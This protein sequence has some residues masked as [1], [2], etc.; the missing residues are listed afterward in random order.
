MRQLDAL[1]RYFPTGTSEGEQSIL[2]DVFIVPAQLQDVLAI[3]EGSPRILVGHKGAGKTAIVDRLA[4][5]ASAHQIPALVLRPDH[6]DLSAI[7]G[8]RDIATIKRVSYECLVAAVAVSVGQRLSGLL[9]NDA[10]RLQQEAV[11][12]GKSE[13][14]FVQRVLG[15]LSSIAKPVTS[16]DFKEIAKELSPGPARSDLVES[17]NAYLLKSQRVNFLFFDDTDQVAAPDDSDQMNRIWG[18]LLAIRRLAHESPNTKCIVTLRSEVW[19]RL[20]RDPKGQ[21]DQI[22]HF[23][24]LVVDLRV[25][26]SLMNAIYERRVELAR[27]LLPKDLRRQAF[28]DDANVTLPGTDEV[29]PWRTFIVKSSRDRPRDMIQLVGEMA[30]TAKQAGRDQ[31][32]SGDAERALHTYSMERARY[33]EAE[34]GSECSTFLDVLRTFSFMPHEVDFESLREHLSTLPSRFGVILRGSTLHP[35]EDS[36][37]PLLQLLYE[38]GFLNARVPDPKRDREFRHVTFADEPYLVSK[39]RWNDLQA[40]RWEVHPAFRTFLSDAREQTG[41]YPRLKG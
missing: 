22:D 27:K 36:V 30:K 11:K 16:T 20:Q 12:L 37:I 1:A 9:S 7:G 38:V 33:L 10:A 34:V 19:A 4:L 18:L 28:F 15:V 32:T 40:V 3:P 41:R 29:R 13:P 25:Q 23:R 6:L 39:E 2:S 8:A 24:P 14:D 17:L 5:A 35:G 31:I 26:E 21:R